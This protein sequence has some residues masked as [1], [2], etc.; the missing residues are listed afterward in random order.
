MLAYAEVDDNLIKLAPVKL[1]K[2]VSGA[3]WPERDEFRVGCTLEHA[4]YYLT[5]L[6]AC[7]GP[8]AEVTAFASLQSPGKPVADGVEGPDFSV[9]VLRFASGF[10]ARLTCS[11]VAP[12]DHALKLFG[13][14]G[15]LRA[16]DCWFYQTPVSYRR[17]M[18]IR[19]RLML[20]PWTNTVPLD[21]APVAVKKGS[22]VGMDFIRGPIEAVTAAREGRPSRVP[23]DFTIH[24][25]EVA[26]AIHDAAAKPGLYKVRSTCE[27]PAPIPS[28]LDA[29]TEHGRLDRHVPPLLARL[30]NA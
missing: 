7:F 5:W 19:R 2:N 22:S 3:P 17:W 13:E 25:N 4:G 10:V 30:F 23:L 16:E 14:E 26:L 15:E 1:W 27:R 24:V 28:P 6:V 12:R 11:V 9:A 18:R 20:S 21:P 8:I 29:R